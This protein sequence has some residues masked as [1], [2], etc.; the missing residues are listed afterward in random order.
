VHAAVIMVGSCVLGVPVLI[1]LLRRLGATGKAHQFHVQGGVSAAFAA[2]KQLRHAVY[3]WQSTQPGNSLGQCRGGAA[4]HEM[5][6]ST[7]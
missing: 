3:R 7:P 1:G 2:T 4:A 5:H 6:Y